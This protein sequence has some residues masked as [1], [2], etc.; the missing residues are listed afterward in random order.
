LEWEL[1]LIDHLNGQGFVVP[2]VVQAAGRQRSVDGVVVQRWIDGRPPES[3]SDWRLVADELQRLHAVTAGHRQRPGCVS[4]DRLAAARRSVDAD[5][6]AM[7]AKAASL[8]IAVF[9]QVVAEAAATGVVP[10][11]VVHGDPGPPN[12]RIGSDG[13]VGLLDWDESRVD[14]AWH[15]LSNLGVQVLDDRAH[16]M[17]KRLSDAWEAANGW[18]AEPSYAKTRLAALFPASPG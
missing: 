8:V 15:D 12:I 9:G 16:A 6:D 10:T 3:D 17:A 2:T 11:S 18:V 5:L 1:D 7:A 4:V 14:L 13:S